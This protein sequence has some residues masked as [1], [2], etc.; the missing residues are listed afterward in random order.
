MRWFDSKLKRIY[1]KDHRWVNHQNPLFVIYLFSSLNFTPF[2][3]D[4]R[5][6]LFSFSGICKTEN[7]HFF[8]QK[9]SLF[10]KKKPLYSIIL[11]DVPF[12]FWVN[13]EPSMFVG[14][15]VV[16]CRLR[17]SPNLRITKDGIMSDYNT[18]NQ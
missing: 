13:C 2:A 11:S 14:R 4:T 10:F 12:L 8:H 6:S 9:I 1:V 17:I 18:T 3:G 15:F 16:F 7:R 5:A